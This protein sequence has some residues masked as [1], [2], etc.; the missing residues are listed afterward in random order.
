MVKDR[1]FTLDEV[2][3]ILPK[4]KRV[5]RRYYYKVE[6]LKEI[7]KASND[8]DELRVI[9]QEVNTLINQWI[10]ELNR[11]DAE[12]KGLW[13]A[14]FDSGDGIYYLWE[15]DEPDILSYCTYDRPENRIPISVWNK[16]FERD[17]DLC[18]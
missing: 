6:R 18:D 11:H 10:E 14:A 1:I 12:G 2:R 17:T 7:F 13:I 15:F 16:V 9:E 3:E 8:I 5:T 4:I